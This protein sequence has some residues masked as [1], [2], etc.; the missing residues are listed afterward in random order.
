MKFNFIYTQWKILSYK[1]QS[2][3]WKTESDF[4]SFDDDLEFR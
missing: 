1:P 4:T 3:V 2:A